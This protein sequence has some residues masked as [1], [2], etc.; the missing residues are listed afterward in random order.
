[1]ARSEQTQG[2][3]VFRPLGRGVV[4]RESRPVPAPESTRRS[5]LLGILAVVLALVCAGVHA[6]AVGAASV[7][8]F[9]RATVL[10]IVAI[11]GTI[12]TAIL[13]FVALVRG[14]G[15]RWGV[16]AVVLSAVANP[17]ALTALLRAV[18]A[19]VSTTSP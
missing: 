10:A 4:P 6:A 17:L 1:M 7:D 16:V 5:A 14:A 8:Q 3:E 12:V 18:D 13:G 19:A 15:R 11:I 2:I 9:E